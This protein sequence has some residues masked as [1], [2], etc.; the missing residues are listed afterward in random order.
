MTAEKVRFARFWE[1]HEFHSCRKM[2][3]NQC[4]FQPLGEHRAGKD[5]FSATSKAVT[6]PKQ[7][8]RWLL[9]HGNY[10]GCATIRK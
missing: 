2:P 5:T 9:A 8:I 3:R 1:G 7:F 10:F 6:Y 4:G